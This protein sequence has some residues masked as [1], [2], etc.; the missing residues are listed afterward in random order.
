LALCPKLIAM[1]PTKRAQTVFDLGNCFRCLGRNHSSHEC[2]KTD[3]ICGMK[4]CNQRHHTLLHGADRVAKKSLDGEV[5]AVGLGT[6]ERTIPLPLY[7]WVNVW[8]NDKMLTVL[9]LLDSGCTTTLITQEVAESF[10]LNCKMVLCRL[11]TLHGNDAKIP[12][13]SS[14]CRITPCGK[15]TPSPTN[16]AHPL[17]VRCR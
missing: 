2:R 4:G 13:S 9:A 3:A 8:N 5:N 14:R 12:V 11:T 1:E 17:N 15:K 16:T 6:A 10:R 7:A